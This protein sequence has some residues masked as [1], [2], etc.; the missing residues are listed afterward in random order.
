MSSFEDQ[1][2]KAGITSLETRID[3]LKELK[4]EIESEGYKTLSQ[5]NGA[6]TSHIDSLYK[7]KDEQ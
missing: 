6:I 1:A 7:L 5:I 4:E 2:R 3:T